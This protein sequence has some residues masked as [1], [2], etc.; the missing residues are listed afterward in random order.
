[1]FYLTF[2]NVH[3]LRVR[4]YHLWFNIAKYLIFDVTHFSFGMY[5]ILGNRNDQKEIEN[6]FL[7]NKS[8]RRYQ[9]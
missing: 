7:K 5:T 6:R 8:S 1:M 2:A 3:S 9:D 4:A